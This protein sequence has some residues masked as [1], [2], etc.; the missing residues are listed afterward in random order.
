MLIKKAKAEILEKVHQIQKVHPSGE[1]FFDA[2]DKEIIETAS[3]EMMLALFS[4]VPKNHFLVLSGGF[5]KII[6]EKIDK[7][8][9]PQLPYYLYNGGIRSGKAPELIGRKLIP[10]MQYTQGIFL[11]DS[12]YG[13]ATYYKLK[14]TFD[15]TSLSLK[16]CAV[17]YDGCPIV[18]D[19]IKS[20]FR[21]YDHFNA[22]PNYKF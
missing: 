15:K 12:I 13:G 19:Y 2:L 3:V 21:Y 11:D 16:K 10:A 20:V 17:I 7:G 18:K 6:A 9:L 14:E 4:L 1:A 8:E 5:G 22:T